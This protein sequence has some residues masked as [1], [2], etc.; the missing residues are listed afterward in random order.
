MSV[1]SMPTA[2]LAEGRLV[3]FRYKDDS[4][5]R[6]PRQGQVTRAPWIPKTGYACV[7]ID[8]GELRDKDGQPVGKTFRLFYDVE[9]VDPATGEVTVRKEIAM[10]V[11]QSV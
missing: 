11:I 2:N 10:R 3:T 1:K 5:V 4:P 6:T 9:I 8:T 7:N